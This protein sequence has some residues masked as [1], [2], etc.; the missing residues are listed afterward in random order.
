MKKTVTTFVPYIF[1]LNNLFSEKPEVTQGATK[2]SRLHHFGRQEPG[3]KPCFT[4]PIRKA[5]VS[6]QMVGFDPA[7]GPAVG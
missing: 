7:A 5:L 1:G 3:K 6:V 4:F 2:T